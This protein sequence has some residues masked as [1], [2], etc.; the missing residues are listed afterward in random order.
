MSNNCRII[1]STSSFMFLLTFYSPRKRR[2]SDDVKHEK[3]QKNSKVD[4]S[5]IKSCKNILGHVT[6]RPILFFHFGFQRIPF[7]IRYLLN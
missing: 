2:L 3:S 5:D 4:V 6:D 1:Y 7:L